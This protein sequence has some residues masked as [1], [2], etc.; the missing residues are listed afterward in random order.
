[1][2]MKCRRQNEILDHQCCKEICFCVYLQTYLCFDES[3]RNHIWEYFCSELNAPIKCLC[4]FQFYRLMWRICD[5][6]LMLE[7]EFVDYRR[8]PTKFI[9]H[10][11]AKQTWFPINFGK[12]TDILNFD[13]L[14]IVRKVKVLW[15]FW[16]AELV[17]VED[18]VEYIKNVIKCVWTNTLTWVMLYP[19]A[20]IIL[21]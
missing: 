3:N 6:R 5:I 2:S 4:A 12:S 19:S 17:E 18:F 9:N 20:N 1:M 10:T 13:E 11:T 21:I 16:F 15:Y 7:K 14:R 8:D